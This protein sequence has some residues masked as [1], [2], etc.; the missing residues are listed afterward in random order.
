MAVR[1]DAD[2]LE[3]LTRTPGGSILDVEQQRAGGTVLLLLHGDLDHR[4][5]DHLEDAV[6]AAL[7]E[8][9]ERLILSCEELSFV[10]SAGLRSL[11][12][13]RGAHPGT[14]MHLVKTSPFV[15]RLLTITGLLSLYD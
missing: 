3:P 13:I 12:G 4:S 8:P 15:A 9:T 7:S 10:D 5:V 11:V 14:K 1:S 2:L 6:E